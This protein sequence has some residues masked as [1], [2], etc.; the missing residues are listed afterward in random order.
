[1]EEGANVLIHNYS[2]S[3]LSLLSGECNGKSIEVQGIYLQ[4][5]V[6][7][8]ELRKQTGWGAW[9]DPLVKCLPSA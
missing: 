6:I 2:L 5:G 8:D 1:M 9:V 4:E 3:S 7:K